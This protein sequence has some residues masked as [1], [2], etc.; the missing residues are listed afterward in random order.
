VTS[1][2]RLLAAALALAACRANAPAGPPVL[3]WYVNPDEG[4]QARLATRCAAASGGRYR[5]AVEDLPRDA[6]QQRE[7][8]VRRLAARDPSIDLMSLDLPFV[9]ELAHAGFLRAFTPE[10]AAPLEAGTLEAPLASSRWLGRLYA[11]PF[12]ASAQLLWYRRSAARRAGI[13]LDGAPVTWDA[14][15]SAAERTK[16]SQAVARS[17]S[18][19]VDFG[20]GDDCRHFA[21]RERNADPPRSSPIGCWHGPCS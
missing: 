13:D 11:A 1:P 15:V 20:C 19:I 17:F 8:L 4:G 16:R 7:Q 2:V 10:E 18:R 5:I 9:P 14:L 21:P 3:T 6:T 12:S